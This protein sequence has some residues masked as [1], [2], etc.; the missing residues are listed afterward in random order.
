VSGGGARLVACKGRGRG[1][2]SSVE[3]T[4]EQ[5]EVGER[6]TG[7]IGARACRGGRR[8]RNRG[9]VH[10]GGTWASVTP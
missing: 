8:T 3:G 9:R 6:G 1:R 4:N 5:G 7:S 10:G 2:E